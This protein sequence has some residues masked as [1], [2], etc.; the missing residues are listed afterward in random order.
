MSGTCN[1]P[2]WLDVEG[3]REAQH[4]LRVTGNEAKYLIAGA[5]FIGAALLMALA[6]VLA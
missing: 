1:D 4:H 2:R 6:A 5:C 3:T